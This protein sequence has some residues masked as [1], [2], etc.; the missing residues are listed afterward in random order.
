VH[1]TLANGGAVWAIR[2]HQDLAPVEG[3]GALLRF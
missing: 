1:Q 2:H 3:I